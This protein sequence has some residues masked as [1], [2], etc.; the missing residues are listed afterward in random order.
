MTL[1]KRLASEIL[2]VGR[3]RIWTDKNR[4][5]D[6][7]KAITRNDVRELIK[8]GAIKARIRIKKKKK[9]EKKG[10]RRGVGSIKKKIARR[11]EKY[12]YKI[13]KLRKYIQNL[14]NKKV[15]NQDEKK[16]LRMMS[17]SG[18]LKSLRHLKDHV[19]NI[20]NKKII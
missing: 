5:E 15:I 19:S 2:G 11:K 20:M 12:V 16:K 10:R 6:I 3:N 14:K 4:L 7:E 9:A 17:R 13:R 1:Q 8:E 18:E